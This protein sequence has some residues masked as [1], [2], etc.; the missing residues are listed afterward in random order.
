MSL[1]TLDA[2]IVGGGPAGLAAAL[3]LGRIN[4]TAVVFDSGVYRNANATEMHTVPLSDG[5]GPDNYRKTARQE[6]T[7]YPTIRVVDR[8]IENIERSDKDGRFRATDGSQEKW[9][10][11]KLILATGSKDILPDIKGM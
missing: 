8:K 3:A 6:L 1:S 5:R 11:K 4:R 7:Q 10:S 9:T 2:I